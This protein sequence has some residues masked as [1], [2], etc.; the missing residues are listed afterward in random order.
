[1]THGDSESSRLSYERQQTA[2][3]ELKANVRG[4]TFVLDAW[5]KFAGKA[6]NAYI[7][8]GAD[9]LEAMGRIHAERTKPRRRKSS[10]KGEARP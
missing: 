5:P 7:A 4:L 1:M 10:T 3:G 8:H 6:F 2:K 9:G